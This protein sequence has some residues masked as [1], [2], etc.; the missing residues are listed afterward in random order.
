MTGFYRVTATRTTSPKGHL[1][2]DLQLNGTKWVSKLAPL[3]DHEKR[4]DKIYQ[5]F[6]NNGGSLRP[7]I[8]KYVYIGFE[9]GK[10]GENITFVGSCDM[11]GEFKSLLDS[12]CGEPFYTFIPIYDFL[13]SRDYAINTDDSITLKPPYSNID[14]A[15]EFQATIC[16]RND[17][18]EGYVNRENIKL[19]YDRFYKDF[20]STNNNPDREERVYLGRISINESVTRYHKNK[21]GIESESD[22]CLVKLGDKLK[23]EHLDFL[24]LI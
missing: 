10:Y 21:G 15:V 7:L 24:N 6:A 19:I 13:K 12:H 3:K 22:T 14:I 16:Y 5:F 23:P 17:L 11:V 9:S 18:K 4:T 2:F 20:E 8:G 1:K